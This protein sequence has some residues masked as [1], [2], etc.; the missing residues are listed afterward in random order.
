MKKY[1]FWPAQ[2]AK[3][4]TANEKAVHTAEELPK[5]KPSGTS[6]RHYVYFFG[7]RNF[8]WI[9]DENIV[10]HTDEM[11]KQVPKKQSAS[12]SKAIQEIIDISNPLPTSVKE[13]SVQEELTNHFSAVQSQSTTTHLIKRGRK[14]KGKN[15]CIETK[16]SQKKNLTEASYLEISPVSNIPSMPPDIESSTVQK[17]SDTELSETQQIFSGIPCVEFIEG[18]IS[19]RG[20]SPPHLHQP[21]IAACEYSEL[22]PVPSVDLSRPNTAAMEK[23]VEPSSCKIGMIGLGM[24]GQRIVK[25][26]LHSGHN[27]SIWNRTPEKCKKFVD[28]G[29]KQFLTPA[30]LVLNCDIIFCCVSGPKVVK[31]IAYKEDGILQGFENSESTEKAYVE[32]TCIDS[33]TSRLIADCIT[34]RGGRYLEA[35][36]IGSILLAEKGSL[37]IFAAGDHTT[38][39]RCFSCFSAISK[40]VCFLSSDVGDASKHILFKV[41]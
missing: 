12:F 34:K 3:P 37:M 5:K 1:P 27:V 15:S 8:A 30:E 2:I 40:N 22:P 35:S 11:F 28:I 4:P 29:A 18:S 19:K 9:S 14:R 36:I 25:N 31:F 32:M 21:T 7:T 26:L 33:D 24:M 23:Y 17:I 41:C 6:R 10:P 13:D 16:K 39:L 20:D 38:F